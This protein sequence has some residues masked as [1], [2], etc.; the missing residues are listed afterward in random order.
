[1]SSAASNNTRIMK[2]TTML[3]IR[4]FVSLAL[5][6]Y[7]SRVVLDVLG[8]SNYGIYNV[9]GGIVVLFSFLQNALSTA[10]QRYL[11][12]EMGKREGGDLKKVF[13]VSITAHF[14]LA[15]LVFVL[16]EI[17]GVWF[18]ENKIN[19]PYE[20]MNA[21]RV[22]FQLSVA[23]CCLN[24][25][26]SPLSSMVVAFEELSFFA[27]LG[28]GES[29]FR[30]FIVYLLIII[31]FDSL[32]VYAAFTFLIF[33]M[34]FILYYLYCKKRHA[35]VLG[36][37]P[38]WDKELSTSMLGFS[39]WSLLLGVANVGCDQGINMVLNVFRGVVVNAAMGVANQV[40]NAVYGFVSN[41]QMAYAPQIVK[42]YAAG[43][44]EELG[45]LVRRTSKFSYFLMFVIS[46]PLVFCC[47]QVLGIWLKEVPD[48][49]TQITRI[50]LC[51]HLVD[52]LSA[53]LW[54]SIQAT[55]KIKYYQIICSFFLI[56]NVPAAIIILKLGYSPVYVI[57]FKF[58]MAF[59]VLL[60]RV[61]YVCVK[62][63]LHLSQ[64]LCDVVL[65]CLLVTIISSFCVWLVFTHTSG[66]YCLLL[67][68]ITSVVAVFVSAYYYG[69]NKGEREFILNLVKQKIL[70]NE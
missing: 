13:R 8:I 7:T 14:L 21:A 28:I 34:L 11:N 48:Y 10:T 57:F 6:L 53:P 23:A 55:G 31:P 43:S 67:S 64:F 52:A 29:I 47:E 4:M 9:V 15:L 70:R 2:N 69:I 26:R 36:F 38:L 22:V 41:F 27:Y 5:S 44:Y 32:I 40:S 18:L 63:H 12:Y 49:A 46:L 20:R 51:I 60:F 24:I 58:I 17:V 54:L 61:P 1:M 62:I 33:L 39:G 42:L 25:I 56:M 19:I 50:I 35:D 3:Y 65:R 68:I 66:I 45:V 59:C 16:A 37:K 30:L